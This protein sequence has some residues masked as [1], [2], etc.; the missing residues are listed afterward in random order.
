MKLLSICY[1]YDVTLILFIKCINKMNPAWDNMFSN[2]K[3]ERF[4]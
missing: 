1:T 2:Y 3:T 4:I